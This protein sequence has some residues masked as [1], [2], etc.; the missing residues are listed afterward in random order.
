MGTSHPTSPDLESVH[1]ND[2]AT[3]PQKLDAGA[4]FVLKSKGSWVHC[5]YHLTTS[6]VAPAL[7]SLPFAFASLGWVAGVISLIAG[8]S[9]TFYSYNLLSIVLEHHAQLGHRQLRFRD[10]ANDIFGPGWGR[11]Y[12]GPVQFL[13]CF[14]AV[15]GSTLLGGQT[16][17]SMY[18]I[19]NP[20]GTAKLYEFVVIFGVFMLV[21][22]Q[23][24]S[25]HS[26]R[27][28][29]L[30]S[31]I[32][33]LAY[34]ACSTAG[35]IYAGHSNRAPKKDYSLLGDQQHR[36]FGAFN[37]ISIIATTYGNGIIPEIQ[38][39]AAAPVTGKMFKGLCLCYTVVVMTFFSVSI[40]GYWAF[41]NQA[42]GTILSNFIVDGT[43]LVPKWFLMMTNIFTLLQL[44]A[45]SVVYLQPTNELLEGL[46]A[47]P[48]KKQYSPRNV[49]PRFISRSLSVATATLIASMLPFFGDINAV[50]G[51][52]GFLP[53]DFV[54]PSVFYNIT[55]RPS[56]QSAIFW[57]NTAIAVV[58]SLF[59]IAGSIS[60]VRQIVLDAN[61][62]KLFA[63]V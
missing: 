58:F 46:F 5:G 48:N 8:A 33:C 9:V 27:H 4:L 37:A 19:S 40:S 62:Y 35:A 34:S 26:L 51:A 3:E 53:L 16:M 21:L 11:Y 49:T 7:L 63:N 17:K 2:S 57:V 50:I 38:A 56:K 43:T 54:V 41:G 52:F 23:I 55:F 39:T 24:P 15:V 30:I 6:I 28:I 25:F 1:P 22:A 59:S 29:N 60:A 61:N 13:V 20:H 12:I 45:V 14:G 44:S 47:D 18:L 31:L 32:L 42:Q 36:V 10:M